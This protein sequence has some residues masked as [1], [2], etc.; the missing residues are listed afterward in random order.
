MRPFGL[1]ADAF[2]KIQALGV[3]AFNRGGKEE[4]LK[5]REEYA[6]QQN[7]WQKESAARGMK[8][9]QEAKKERKKQFARMMDE[10][11]GSKPHLPEKR[12]E[13]KR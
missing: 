6:R 8:I 11:S 10:I 3:E 5:V 4:E 12:K 9:E 7:A 1:R 2:Q 13:L